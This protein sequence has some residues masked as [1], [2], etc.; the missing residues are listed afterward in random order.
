MTPPR[1]SL[2]RL[3]TVKQVADYYQVHESTVKRWMASGAVTVTRLGP[4]RAV[5]IVL[6][7]DCVVFTTASQAT[8]ST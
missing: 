4:R 8:S 5:R 7:D 3:A 1:I 6:D 2:P